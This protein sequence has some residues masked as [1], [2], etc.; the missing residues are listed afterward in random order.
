MFYWQ[1]TWT[2]TLDRGPIKEYNMNDSFQFRVLK[3]HSSLIFI[4]SPPCQLSSSWNIPHCSGFNSSWFETSVKIYVHPYWIFRI[5]CNGDRPQSFSYQEVFKLLHNLRRELHWANLKCFGLGKAT[6]NT[7]LNIKFWSF[8]LGWD[9][10]SGMTNC[11]PFPLI[12]A[13]HNTGCPPI[14]IPKRNT[15][16]LTLS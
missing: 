13:A 7:L 12:V 1:S 9:I 10:L 2:A 4:L 15:A 14:S 16:N 5:Y 6:L 8:L 11:N 3:G